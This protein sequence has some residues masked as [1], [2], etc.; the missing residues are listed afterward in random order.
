MLRQNL[1]A[2]AANPW[3]ILP[4]AHTIP[5]TAEP[6]I[7][8]L[9]APV[10]EMQIS[11]GLGTSTITC[12]TS[13]QANIW[14][15]AHFCQVNALRWNDWLNRKQRAVMWRPETEWA[16]PMFYNFLDFET[17]HWS[18]FQWECRIR[19]I[20]IWTGLRQLPAAWNAHERPTITCK[21]TN[22]FLCGPRFSQPKFTAI[23][24]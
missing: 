22:H 6:G 8:L 14:R 12:Y 17:S 18:Y 21:V 20:G 1:R 10:L 19:L 24:V 3:K 11:S 13:I 16:G 4:I 7:L 5:T 15:W 23:C 2:P 9:F